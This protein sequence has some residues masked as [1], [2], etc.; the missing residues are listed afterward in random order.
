MIKNTWYM[1]VHKNLY[2]VLIQENKI[3]LFNNFKKRMNNNISTM[4]QL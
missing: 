1:L 2:M 3:F 4:F